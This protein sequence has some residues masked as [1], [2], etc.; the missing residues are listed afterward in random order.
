MQLRERVLCVLTAVFVLAWIVVGALVGIGTLTVSWTPPE[1][2]A[3][4]PE[5]LDGAAPFYHESN[6]RPRANKTYPE[7]FR[8]G[9]PDG[10]ADERSR[11]RYTQ[12][13]GP[14]DAGLQA[15]RLLMGTLI[16]DPKTTYPA[17][18]HPA[19]EIYY[20]LEGEADWYVDERMQKVGPGTVIYHRPH[21]IHGW[22]NTS[23]T[24]PLRALWVWWEEGDGT[25]TVLNVGAKL[26]DPEGAKTEATALPN[27]RPPRK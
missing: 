11:Y 4:I 25:P 19:A 26:T 13:V 3:A 8:G 18:S 20:I 10:W 23:P 16:L 27:T 1:D 5:G 24:K 2:R 12:L 14:K 22:R 6:A 7:W 21:A 15:A 9:G 17:H